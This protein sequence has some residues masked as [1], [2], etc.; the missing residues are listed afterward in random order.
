MRDFHNIEKSAFHPG[1]YV[2]YASG[3]V[4]RIKR[5][6]EGRWMATERDNASCFTRATLAQVSEALEASAAYLL[7]FKS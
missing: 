7:H 4:W 6:A 1:Q 3:T 2:G 5:T